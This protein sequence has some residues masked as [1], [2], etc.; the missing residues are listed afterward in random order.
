MKKRHESTKN[1]LP[2][3]VFNNITLDGINSAYI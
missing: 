1:N 2:E 3:Y